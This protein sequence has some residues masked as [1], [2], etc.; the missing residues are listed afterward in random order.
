MTER[1]HKYVIHDIIFEI[2]MGIYGGL[3][4]PMFW[5]IKTNDQRNEWTN[6][7]DQAN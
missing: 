4:K 1:N 7:I 3:V 5:D 6:K 2:V